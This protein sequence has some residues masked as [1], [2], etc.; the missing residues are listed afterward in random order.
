MS[1]RIWG[2][3]AAVA[4]MVA[5]ASIWPGW[6]MP[7]WQCGLIGGV[8]GFCAVRAL[9]GRPVPVV[10]NER[11]LRFA[12]KHK[13]PQ[14]W[15]DEELDDLTGDDDA[16]S[17]AQKWAAYRKARRQQLMEQYRKRGHKG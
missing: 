3:L 16:A 4:L 13:P 14:A 2:S 15:Y 6:S 11:L 7:Y 10:S 1:R 5:V 17:T 12:E 9:S 8:F